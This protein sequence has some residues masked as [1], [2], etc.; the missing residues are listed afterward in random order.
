M[1]QNRI[2][3]NYVRN[4]KIK[5]GVTLLDFPKNFT[6]ILHV[7]VRRCKVQIISY[8]SVTEAISTIRIISNG[9]HA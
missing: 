7:M 1:Q 2:I 3:E 5:S 6:Y 9:D 4:K 8:F